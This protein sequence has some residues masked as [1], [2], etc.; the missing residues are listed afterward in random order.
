[1]NTV[2]KG[3]TFLEYNGF[4]TGYGRG[5]YPYNLNRLVAERLKGCFSP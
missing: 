2:E 3:E 5:Q 4:G 1:V